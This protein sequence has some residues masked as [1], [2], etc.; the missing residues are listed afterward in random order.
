MDWTPYLGPTATILVFVIGG[1]IAVKNANNARFSRIEAEQA[2]MNATLN[3]LAEDVR[4]TRELSRQIAGLSAKMD[5]LRA[6]VTKHNNL[7]E[8]V[9]KLESDNHTAFHRIDELRDDIHELER[10]HKEVH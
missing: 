8:R 4:A 1:W 10:Y 2:A 9:Y 3:Q 6:D 5:D 7:V